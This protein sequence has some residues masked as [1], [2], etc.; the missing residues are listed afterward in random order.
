M[1][2]YK[3]QASI[4]ESVT[5]AIIPGLLHGIKMKHKSGEVLHSLNKATLN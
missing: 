4:L 5:P 1:L 2:L 3:N